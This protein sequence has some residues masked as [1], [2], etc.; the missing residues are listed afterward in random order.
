VDQNAG[1]VPQLLICGGIEAEEGVY[2]VCR[3]ERCARQER[4]GIEAVK[5][6][7]LELCGETAVCSAVE[8][9]DGSY[10][11]ALY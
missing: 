5:M 3:D 6:E 8:T 11:A 2:E 9:E 1:T 10:S 4:F 7:S